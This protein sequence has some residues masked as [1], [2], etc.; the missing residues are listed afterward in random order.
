MNIDGLPPG[1]I[2]I[3][4]DIGEIL[5]PR[6]FVPVPEVIANDPV[7]FFRDDLESTIQWLQ[8]KAGS[9]IASVFIDPYR[10]GKD[11]EV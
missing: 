1:E 2:E 6:N 11:D 10:P 3:S 8:E 9:G 5:D 7:L 4:V